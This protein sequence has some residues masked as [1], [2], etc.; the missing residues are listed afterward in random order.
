MDFHR[1][2]EAIAQLFH[3]DKIDAD[4]ARRQAH[5]LFDTSG[6][7]KKDR[8][9]F[10]RY[11][12][13]LEARVDTLFSVCPTTGKK[14]IKMTR[15]KAYARVQCK[16]CKEFMWTLLFVGQNSCERCAN[17]A[18]T[19]GCGRPTPSM[20]SSEAQYRGDRFER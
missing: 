12:R 5:A 10:E 7:S 18:P 13:P 20:P 14:G 11:E 9:A 8:E 1:K 4:E 16:G 6:M 15:G 2:L 19:S 3:D 17:P